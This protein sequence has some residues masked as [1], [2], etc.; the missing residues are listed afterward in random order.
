M[1]AWFKSDKTDSIVPVPQVDRNVETN[2]RVNPE[3]ENILLAL[4][5]FTAVT[6]GALKE[7]AKRKLGC[8]G[9]RVDSRAL[10]IAILVGARALDDLE[11]LEPIG[12]L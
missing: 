4:P 12:T 2:L 9:I 7:A 8:T 3:V 10:A 6:D 1:A 11:L 5:A